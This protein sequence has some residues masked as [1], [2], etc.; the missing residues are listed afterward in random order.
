MT[1]HDPVYKHTL[2]LSLRQVLPPFPKFRQDLFCK[3]L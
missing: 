1:Q 2:A 3:S